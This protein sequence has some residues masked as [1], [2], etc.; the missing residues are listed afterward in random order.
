MQDDGVEQRLQRVVRVTHRRGERLGAVG[1]GGEGLRR[2]ARASWSCSRQR[3][4]GGPAAADDVDRAGQVA[5]Q[6][7]PAEGGLLERSRVGPHGIALREVA[8]QQRGQIAE[9]GGGGV[10]VRSPPARGSSKSSSP[11][12]SRSGIWRRVVR[13]QRPERAVA[14]RDQRVGELVPVEVDRPAHQLVVDVAEQLRREVGRPGSA[15]SST[16]CTREPKVAPTGRSAMGDTVGAE[17]RGRPGDGGR[18]ER[19]VVLWR[20]APA[21]SRPLPPARHLDGGQRGVRRAPPRGVDGTR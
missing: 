21:R 18:S 13:G 6:A 10:R 19:L 15:C 20:P 3:G 1:R 7:L 5:A 4:S 9:A 11:R 16:A 2:A 8:A 14:D 17:A 12:R